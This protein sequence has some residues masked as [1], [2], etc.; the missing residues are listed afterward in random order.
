[1]IFVL[2]ALVL[3]AALTLSAMRLISAEVGGGIRELQAGQVFSVA[4]A[5]IHY[6]I[7]KLQGPQAALYAGETI[8]MTGASATLGRAAITVNCPDTGAAPPCGGPYARY[9]RIISTGSLPVSGPS[10]TVVAVVRATAG[11]PSGICAYGAAV[12]IGSATWI[13]SNVG[14]N[15]AIDLVGAAPAAHISA[16]DNRPQQFTGTAE[17]MGP[18]VCGTACAAQVQG[19][20]VPYRRDPVCPPVTAPSFA[21][22]SANLFVPP[23]GFTMNSRTG[24]AWNDVYIGPGSCAGRAPFTDLNLQADPSNPKA[25]TVVQVNAL[26][27]GNCS[28]IVILGVGK[29][30]LRVAQARGPGLL[31]LANTRIAVLPSDTVGVPAPVPAGRFVV[32]VNSNKSIDPT[33]EVQFVNARVVSGTFL[34]PRGRIYASS[35]PSVTGVLWGGAVSLVASN[36][37]SDVSGLPA[38][39]TLSYSD[40]RELRSWKAE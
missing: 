24:Y 31:A 13:H 38:S 4:Q 2:V 29:I 18:I 36:F 33:M 1:M 26:V 32:W 22:G 19:G 16:D 7:G 40:F 17:A 30:E 12:D 20:T 14:S 21:R 35:L 10:R 39:A 25:T 5:G 28:R 15:A 34:A 23:T 3:V 6:A 27:M 9:R 37:F 11:G 8:T